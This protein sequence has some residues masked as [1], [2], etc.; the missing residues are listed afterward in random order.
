MSRPFSLSMIDF[1]L[2]S[3]IP[4]WYR[5]IADINFMRFAISVLY[6]NQFAGQ[7]FNCTVGVTENC[8]YSTGDE[9]LVNLGVPVDLQVWNNAVYIL[10][11][12]FIMHFFAFL[13]VTFCFTN[14]HKEIAKSCSE[15]CGKK[16]KKEI[17]MN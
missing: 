7:V 14:A 16:K 11:I 10:I 6:Y 8:F 1:A 9:A 3:T 5:W 12:M 17:E 2:Y 4:V 15:K 13:A